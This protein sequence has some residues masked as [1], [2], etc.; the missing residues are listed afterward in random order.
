MAV[1]VT[2]DQAALAALRKRLKDAGQRD[3]AREL[4]RSLKEAAAEV[5]ADERRTAGSLPAKSSRHRL[6]G[7]LAAGVKVSVTSSKTAPGVRI[8][9][10]APLAKAAQARSFRHPVFGERGV[11]V[12]QRLWPRWFDRVAYRHRR[13]VERKVREAIGR[14]TRKINSD[15]RG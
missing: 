7:D 9:D 13:D 2:V 12:S 8:V 5:A 4:T 15:A 11:W 6:R 3:L 10:Q 14:I 1:E